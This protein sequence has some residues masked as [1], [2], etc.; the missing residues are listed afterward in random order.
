MAL[1][2]KPVRQVILDRDQVQYLSYDAS[3]DTLELEVGVAWTRPVGV[4]SGYEV[5]VVEGMTVTD[6]GMGE[7][8]G[9][10][11]VSVS[12]MGS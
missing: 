2:P 11:T 7:V 4:V 9:M 1:P 6:V 10:E 3:T 5:R 12:S 8:F